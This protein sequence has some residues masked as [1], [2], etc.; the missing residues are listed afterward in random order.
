MDCSQASENKAL[1]N[2]EFEQCRKF[3]N[4]NSQ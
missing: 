4:N 2:D 3:K 1:N